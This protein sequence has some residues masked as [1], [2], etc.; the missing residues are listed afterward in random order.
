LRGKKPSIDKIEYITTETLLTLMDKVTRA[1]TAGTRKYNP[2]QARIKDIY[3]NPDSGLYHQYTHPGSNDDTQNIIVPAS[4]VIKTVA[5]QMID[6][7]TI[8][9]RL[10]K[11]KSFV[12]DP[13]FSHTRTSLSQDADHDQA[14]QELALGAAN[15]TEVFFK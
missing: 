12:R 2:T 15:V 14:I 7:E 5:R 10:D 13:A 8:A 9:S 4:L 3:T 11:L 1:A 6:V